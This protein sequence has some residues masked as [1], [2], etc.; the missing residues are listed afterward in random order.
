M[1]W[2][3]PRTRKSP[4]TVMDRGCVAATRS[5][6]ILLVTASWKAPSLRNDQR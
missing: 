2:I 6:R 3:P 1:V 4:A 5:S